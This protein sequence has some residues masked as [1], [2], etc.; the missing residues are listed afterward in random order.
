MTSVELEKQKNEFVASV[1]ACI[2]KLE[3][4]KTAIKSLQTTLADTEDTLVK[5][6]IVERISK[7]ES[8]V[9]SKQSALES[10]MNAGISSINAEIKRLKDQEAYERLK[11]Q[12]SEETEE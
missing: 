8:V 11:A 2:E 3:N 4:A 9:S 6:S 10:K 1:N 7:L 12:E 5:E